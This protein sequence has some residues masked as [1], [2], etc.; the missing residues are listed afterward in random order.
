MPETLY[1]MLDSF[2]RLLYVGRTINPAIRLNDHR[3]NKDWWN[4][5]ATITLERFDSL[6]E[7][8]DAELMAI[9]AEHPIHNI[10]GGSLRMRIAAIGLQID[11]IWETPPGTSLKS[12]YFIH[13]PP[14]QCDADQFEET[15]KRALIDLEVLTRLKDRFG[16]IPTV[17]EVSA[18]IRR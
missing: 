10:V 13:W 9:R 14:E 12:L 7:L 1:R 4:D 16:R 18:E 11:E 2:D 15:Y 3:S 8:I 17:D 6:Q 5:V